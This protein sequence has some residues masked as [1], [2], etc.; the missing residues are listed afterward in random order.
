MLLGGGMTGGSVKEYLK[1]IP[2]RYMKAGRVERGRILDGFVRLS[3]VSLAKVAFH[4]T[5]G[6]YKK[7]APC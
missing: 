1:A 4:Q 6:V 3:A 5:N 2:D 7:A